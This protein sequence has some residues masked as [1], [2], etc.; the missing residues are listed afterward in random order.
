MYGLN[1]YEYHD[2][3]EAKEA[4]ALAF[5]SHGLFGKHAPFTHLRAISVLCFKE[6]KIIL[7]GCVSLD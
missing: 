6:Q 7:E 4:L 3:Y 2:L 1:S 5:C